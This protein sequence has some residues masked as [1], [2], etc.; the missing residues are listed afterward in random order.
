MRK[1]LSIFLVVMTLAFSTVAQ[2][3][4][5][6]PGAPRSVSV[7]PVKEKKLANGLTVVVVEKHSSPLVTAQLLIK[8][9]A[10]SEA[11]E[12][13]GLANLTND[14]LT[15]GTRTRTATQIA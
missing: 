9:G 10:R 5:P 3:T 14:A 13:A 8:G 2:E 4:A 12:K 15:K 6:T 11:I 1:A 7:P